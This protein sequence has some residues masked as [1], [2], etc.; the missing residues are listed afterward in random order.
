MTEVN[1]KNAAN[2]GVNDL[3]LLAEEAGV[4]V[5]EDDNR[6]TLLKK[7]KAKPEAD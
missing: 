6:E 7:L 4:K 5:T 3:I 1:K 2:L